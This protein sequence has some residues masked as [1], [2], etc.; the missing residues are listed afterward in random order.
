MPSAWD[1]RGDDAFAG[2]YGT[3]LEGRILNPQRQERGEDDWV[4]SES[5]GK[6]YRGAGGIKS[7]SEK[8]GTAERD[9]GAS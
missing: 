1:T 2:F 8:S 4:F 3:H 9:P 5:D 7:L 6:V